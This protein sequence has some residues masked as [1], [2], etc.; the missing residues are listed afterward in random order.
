M[1]L[2]SA[3]V[4]IGTTTHAGR[5]AQRQRAPHRRGGEGCRCFGGGYAG[6]GTYNPPTL[7]QVAPPISALFCFLCFCRL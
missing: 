6:W 3:R 5:P 4:V 2:P 7:T 1:I